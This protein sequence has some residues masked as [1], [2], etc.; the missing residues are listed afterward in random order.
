VQSLKRI[1]FLLVLGAVGAFFFRTAL[2]E[3]IYIKSDSMAP[4]LTQGD[5]VFVNKAVLFFRPP[6]RGE[7]VTFHTP[8]QKEAFKDLVKRVIAVEG[9]RIEIKEKQVILNGE[10]LKEPYVQRI[11]PHDI[12][13][14]DNIAP[15]LIPKGYVFLMGDN[16]DVSMDSRD[17]TDP[18]GAWSP[19]VPVDAIQGVVILP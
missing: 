15:I 6:R 11:R 12:L 17:F 14:G 7:I 18:S 4:T 16:R 1:L 10:P 8:Q 2:F 19:Y 9:D 3:G 5:H 13:K